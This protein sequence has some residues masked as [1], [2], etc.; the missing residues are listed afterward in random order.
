MTSKDKHDQY[1]AL[2]LAQ[3]DIARTKSEVPVGA[4]LVVDDKI[5]AM[6]HNTVINDNDPTAHAEVKCIRKAGVV[7]QNYRI[8]NSTLYTT[9]EPCPM[10]ASTAIQA[11]I[12][13]IVIGASDYKTGACGS[14]LSLHNH[15]SLNHEIEVDFGVKQDEC[16]KIITDFFKK[17]RLKKKI[18]KV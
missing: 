11:R 12:S 2:A 15:N 18:I 9:L 6:E 14:V 8:I 16:K 13:K 3:A 7:L 10:C 17:I 5:I 4:V 1:M